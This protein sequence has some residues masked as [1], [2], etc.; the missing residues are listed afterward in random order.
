MILK[1]VQQWQGYRREKESI[2]RAR[3]VA[4]TT[5]VPDFVLHL[6]HK[7]SLLFRVFFTY[8]RHQSREGA[9]IRPDSLRR[10]S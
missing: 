4:P 7:H 1:V 6:N 3:P 9:A 8:M 2:G 5:Q 10:K